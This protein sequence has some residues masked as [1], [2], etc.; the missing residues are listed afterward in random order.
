MGDV[1][2]SLDAI[3]KWADGYMVLREIGLVKKGRLDAVLVPMNFEASV[4]RTYKTVNYFQR[5][6]LVGVE[7]KLSRSD[8]TRGLKSGQFKRYQGELAGLYVATMKGVCKTKELP[9][10]IGHLVVDWLPSAKR[11]VLARDSG[12]PL[13]RCVC[14]RHPKW[15]AVQ[16]TQEQMWRILHRVN[17]A[18]NN[19]VK[20]IR[21][22]Y[23]T[24]LQMIWERVGRKIVDA[25]RR[26]VR[27]I[28]R[29]IDT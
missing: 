9:A 4:A 15:S 5:L 11:R 27:Q 22:Q 28:E 2:T 12:R 1:H 25:S 18:M 10:G 7:L 21:S 20:N 14:R 23:D 26:A 8:F 16:M 24:K 6:G 3:E 13:M 29:T 19:E 17:S